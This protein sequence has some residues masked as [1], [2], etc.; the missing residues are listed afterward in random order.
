MKDVGELLNEVEE[1]EKQEIE[2]ESNPLPTDKGLQEKKRKLHATIHRVAAY[3][4]RN[5]GYM[6]IVQYFPIR[7]SMMVTY[8]VF[9]QS[10]VAKRRTKESA[11]NQ[12]VSHLHTRLPKLS[13]FNTK[14]IA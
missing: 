1:I 13:C 14:L 9:L 7:F 8:F 5:Y 10:F 6:Y 3:Y 11:W 4:V 2:A 12:A